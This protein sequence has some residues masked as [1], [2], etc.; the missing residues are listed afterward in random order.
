MVHTLNKARCF[1]TTNTLKTFKHL[2]LLFQVLYIYDSY[3]CP[4]ATQKT[5][6]HRS[7]QKQKCPFFLCSK[8]KVMSC[9]K[10]QKQYTLVI[11]VA[12]VWC[13]DHEIQGCYQ[14]GLTHLQLV[15]QL[16]SFHLC[17]ISQKIDITG[18]S[19]CC[20]SLALEDYLGS[21]VMAML[22]EL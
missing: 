17:C 9:Q 11:S 5:V 16:R 6:K 10:I 12:C 7:V 4:K 1:S 19:L 8:S 2:D 3:S 22:S 18:T 21:D 20:F 14:I 15:V 13:T